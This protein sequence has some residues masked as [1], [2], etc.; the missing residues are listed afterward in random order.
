MGKIN[1]VVLMGVFVFRVPVVFAVECPGFGELAR[2]AQRET[3][4]VQEHADTA[5]TALTVT[6]V[7]DI[8]AGKFTSLQDFQDHL[9]RIMPKSSGAANLFM[10]KGTGEIKKQSALSQRYM[11][12]LEGIKQ[13][14]GVFDKPKEGQGTTA[15]LASYLPRWLVRSNDR[16]ETGQDSFDQL[17]AGVGEW[18][19]TIEAN[20]VTIDAQQRIW[21]EESHR[22]RQEVLAWEKFNRQLVE[23]L[24]G[25]PAS[26]IRTMGEMTLT[27]GLDLQVTAQQNLLNA[28]DAIQKMQLVRGNQSLSLGVLTGTVLVTIDGLEREGAL[29]AANAPAAKVK[30]IAERLRQRREQL[31]LQLAKEIVNTSTSLIALAKEPPISEKVQ[32]QINQQIEAARMAQMTHVQGRTDALLAQTRSLAAKIAE[33]ELQIA[34]RQ[35]A[36]EVTLMLPGNA[37]RGQPHPSIPGPLH[38]DNRPD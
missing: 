10:M 11:K 29:A 23:Q 26:S 34:E 7:Q 9:D 12:A 20:I 14:L 8:A 28:D 24:E 22:L 18:V 1:R 6:L 5:A 37:L 3:A 2:L 16:R 17:R 32:A 38:L 27:R 36:D 33:T 21:G 4:R 25:L 19:G 31:G 30:E 15:M 13:E 35:Q